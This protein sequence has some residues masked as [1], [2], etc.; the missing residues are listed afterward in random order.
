MSH[1]QTEWVYISEGQIRDENRI[2]LPETLFDDAGILQRGADGVWSYDRSGLVVL[3]NRKLVEI[4]TGR[5]YRYIDSNGIDQN[6]GT[7][8]PGRFFEDYEGH[9][10]PL[11][12]EGTRYTPRF[13]YGK[14]VFFAAHKGMTTGDT[15]SCYVLT[16]DQLTD[17][18]SGRDFGDTFD[19]P[20][21]FI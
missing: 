15:R 2:T 19:S 11:E 16:K 13:E 20:P 10:G 12:D 9:R 4:D 14:P 5:K 17:I 7:Y 21:R 6:R 1:S 18:M 8:I 3:S